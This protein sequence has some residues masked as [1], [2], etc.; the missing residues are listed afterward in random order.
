MLDIQPKFKKGDQIMKYDIIGDIH[1]HADQLRQ[2]LEKLGYKK[3]DGSYTP[4][5]DR[6]AIF[7][8]DFIDRGPQI[9]Q[10]LEIVKSMCDRGAARAVLGNHEYNALCYNTQKPGHAE[11]WLRPR[12]EKNKMQHKD[13]LDQFKNHP[14]EWKNYLNWFMT[15]PLFLDLGD[16]RI[17][18]A[19]WV[20]SA[21]D[22]IRKWTGSDPKG[23]PH[24]TPELLQKSAQKRSEE[25]NVFEAVLKGVEIVLP[26]GC[27]LEDKDGYLRNEARIRWWEPAADKS[28]G[29]MIFPGVSLDCGDQI[30]EPEKV[31]GLSH[32]KEPI[33]VFFGHYWRNPEI[34]Q[35]KVQTVYICCLDYSVAKEGILVAYRWEGEKILRND[36]FE[37]V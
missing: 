34:H 37:F 1:G 20:S 12:T 13:T 7:V 4:P 5:S 6:Q 21:L 10:T 29:E 33:P 25:Y 9:R 15:L 28:Y 16:I 11:E 36:R 19:A 23:H 24:L 22:K 32:Y 31:E 3:K 27:Q 30:I 8:G 26:N 35:L 17:V 18:H 14:V 2:L